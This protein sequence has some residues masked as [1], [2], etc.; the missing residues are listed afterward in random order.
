MTVNFSNGDTSKLVA[1]AGGLL[2]EVVSVTPADD[3]F[4]NRANRPTVTIQ[5][6]NISSMN[7]V[8][9]T[10]EVV[11]STNA[12]VVN[13]GNVTFGD[14]ASGASA[15]AVINVEANEDVYYGRDV[16]FLLNL[17]DTDGRTSHAYAHTEIGPVDQSA[18]TGPDAYGY[19]AYDIYDTG[20]DVPAPTY[21]WHNIDPLDGGK[22]YRVPLDGRRL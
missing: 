2:F 8:G 15:S 19:Y 7:A 9:V 3:G 22:R 17:T 6:T 20:Y 5:L 18:P 16:R 10:A 11:S 1:V 13:S 4:I 14:I 12:V 21:Q